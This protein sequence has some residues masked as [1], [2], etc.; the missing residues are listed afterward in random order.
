MKTRLKVISEIN[1][2]KR[3]IDK[4]SEKEQLIKLNKDLKELEN[5]L[6]KYRK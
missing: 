4:C 1:L 5:E 6:T 3:E 2:K